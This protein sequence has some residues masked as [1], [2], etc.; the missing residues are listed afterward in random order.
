MDARES[1][2]REGNHAC[3]RSSKRFWNC[4]ETFPAIELGVV[5]NGSIQDE[6]LIE[7]Y[8]QDEKVSI[9]VSLDGSCEEVNARTR[10]VGN[11]KTR[12]GLYPE[13]DGDRA[14]AAGQNGDLQAQL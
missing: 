8:L 12:A 11:F 2:W 3:I 1:Y 14:E 10:G 6:C 4:R 7:R 13:I 9:Q 5:T